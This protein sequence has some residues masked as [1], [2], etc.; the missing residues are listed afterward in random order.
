MSIRDYLYYKVWRRLVVG[1]SNRDV[2]IHGFRSENS[3]FWRER[4]IRDRID[5]ALRNPWVLQYNFGHL[6]LIEQQLNKVV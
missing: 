2:L 6:Q 5:Y 1:M 3:A 4:T